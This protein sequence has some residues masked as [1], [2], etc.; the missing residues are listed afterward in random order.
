MQVNAVQRLRRAMARGLR[1]W[2][3]LGALSERVSAVEGKLR[4]EQHRIDYALG[5]IEGVLDHYEA[6]RT[7]REGDEYQRAFTDN[8]PLVTVCIATSERA[9]LLT[10]RC[11][12][13]VLAQTYSNLQ[14]VVVGDHCLDDTAA[15][16]AALGDSRV[17]FHNL[18]ER[19]PYPPPGWERWCVAGT[20]AINA[21]LARAEG[22]FITHLDDDDR[23]TPERVERLVAEAQQHRADLCWHP[24]WTEAWDGSWS[25]LG[26]GRFEAGQVTTG[27]TLYHRYF[28]SFPWDV[29]AY[30][31][32][33]PGDWNRLRKIKLMRPTMRFVGQPLL[34]HYKERNQAPF[35]AQ[36]NEQFLD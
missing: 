35:I 24:M 18:P 22:Q 7:A 23:Y 9:R 8:N 32:V 1:R 19:G 16:V 15:R 5:A 6:F 13:S 20:S 29:F 4:G 31:L 30:R 17:E 11:L 14:I 2:N 33:E 28:Q 3:P 27:S 10:E 25:Q 26:N 12:P 21:A 36:A 34:Y